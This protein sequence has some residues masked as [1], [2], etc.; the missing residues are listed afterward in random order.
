MN[1]TGGMDGLRGTWAIYRREMSDYFNQPMAYVVITAYLLICGWFFGGTLF[2]AGQA[3]MRS[4]FANLPFLLIFFTPAITMRLLAEEWKSGTMDLLATLPIKDTEVVAGKFL[5]AF[6]V[7]AVAQGLTLIY[8]VTVASLGD[9]DGGRIVSGYVGVLLLG[10]AY[11]AI[12]V[13]ASAMTSNQ[14]VAFIVS[15]FIC[16]ALV[17]VGGM[18]QVLPDVVVPLF[19]FL[20]VSDHF[21]NLVKG[22]LDSRDLLYFVSIVVL[23]LAGSV[24]ALQGRRWGR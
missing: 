22:V 9:P 21:G 16:F 12:G 15:F 8:V 5:A 1:G 11:L 24:N 13:F 10:A 23:C 2:L 3:D 19:Q 4:Y 18:L 6:S 7:F 14:V 17:Q 20:S